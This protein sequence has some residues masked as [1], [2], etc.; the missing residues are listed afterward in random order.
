MYA[1]YVIDYWLFYIRSNHDKNIYLQ[2]NYLYI[3][4]NN[5]DT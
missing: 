3:S 4:Y 1:L 5:M 2:T